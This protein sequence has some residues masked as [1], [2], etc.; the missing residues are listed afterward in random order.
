M[1]VGASVL[2]PATAALYTALN[3]AA[4]SA[5]CPGGAVDA[6]PVAPNYP[7]AWFTLRDDPRGLSTFGRLGADVEVRLQVYDVEGPEV[8]GT[9]RIDLVLDKA[10]ELLHHQEPA[11]TGWTT[12]LLE[13]LGSFPLGNLQDEASRLIRTKVGIFRWQLVKAS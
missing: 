2:D 13:Y 12:E 9:K 10:A 3:V 7:Y 8:T 1:T 11:V 6:V 4:F 5:L